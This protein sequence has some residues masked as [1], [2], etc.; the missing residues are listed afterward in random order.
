VFQSDGN[1]VA[2][3]LYTMGTLF[4][5]RERFFYTKTSFALFLFSIY[6]TRIVNWMFFGYVCT[7]S[8]MIRPP[9]EI[10]H[11]LVHKTAFDCFTRLMLTLKQAPITHRN[12]PLSGKKNSVAAHSRGPDHSPVDPL[13]LGRRISPHQTPPLGRLR[14]LDCRAIG[15]SVAFHLQLEH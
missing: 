2:I 3:F 12:A 15:V 13:Q 11:E 4:I 6:H 1:A 5:Q 9:C 8:W 14:H 10:T 7:I